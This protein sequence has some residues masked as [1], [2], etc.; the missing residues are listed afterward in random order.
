MTKS[1]Y[2]KLALETSKAALPKCLP[3]PPVGCVIVCEGQI[4]SVGHTYPPGIKHAEVD[5]LGRVPLYANKLQVYVTLEPCSFQGRTPS[6]ALMLANDSRVTEIYVAMLDPDP[7]N[8]GR[9]IEILE[10]AGKSVF[11]GLEQSAV[12]NFIT[13]YLIK[14]N[15]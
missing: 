3:N 15:N 6:C 2:M 7:R 1:D 9:G 5:A 12:S 13:P 10:Q 14:P 4:V 11:V 8:S